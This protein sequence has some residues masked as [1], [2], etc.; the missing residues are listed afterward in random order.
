M[1]SSVFVWAAA[2]GLVT[3]FL[4]HKYEPSSANVA[5][6]VLPIQ[7]VAL[8]VLLSEP[9][10]R[11]FYTYVVFL[12][13]LSLSI[14]VYRLSPFHPLAQY[15]GPAIAKVTKLWSFWKTAQGYKYLWH[16]ELHDKYGPYVRTGPNEIS[17]IDAPAV[18]QILNFGGLEKGRY[19]ESGRHKDTPPAIVCLSGEAHTA[20]RRVWNRAMTSACIREYEPLIVKRASQLISCLREQTGSVDLVH[21]LDLFAYDS[22]FST[23]LAL[24]IIRYDLM[25]DLAFGGGFEMLRDGRDVD[26]VGERIRGYTKASYLTGQ[27]PWIVG[28]IHL[29]PQV[30]REIQQFNDFGQNLAMQ[31]M[32]NGAADEG[33]FEKQKPSLKTSAADGIVAVVAASDTTTSALNSTVWFLLSN[34]EC[35]R[36]VRQELD[37][38]F[39]DGDDPLDVNK[40]PELHFL[41]AC[42]NEALRLHPPLPSNGP[43]QV[44]LGQSGKTIAGRFIPEGTSVYTP[45][46]SLHRNPDYF[47]PHPNKF[48][49][50]RWL[51]DSKFEKHDTSAFIPFS[52]GPANCVGQK[53]AKREMLMVLSALFKSFDMR[54]ADGFDSEAWPM[55]MQDFFVASRGPLL[56]NLIP[57]ESSR[58]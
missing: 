51:P 26:G 31:R 7:P 17:V 20:K 45:A 15:P 6:L 47:S 55:G 3:H 46:Y 36:R 39:S 34:P 42:I 57:R 8:L 43:R 10:S 49:P 11:L 56:V 58:L 9:F 23:G 2:L 24:T 53:F 22:S 1:D 33:G 4:F 48:L 14:I 19:Y 27:L 13:T 5:L 28:T 52:L 41:S 30:A 50:E 29:F 21:W 32:K 25:G 37:T 16:K 40:Q 35:Y 54:F 12:G 38:V 44:H 18:S